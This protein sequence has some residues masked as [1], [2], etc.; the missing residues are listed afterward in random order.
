MADE[1]PPPGTPPADQQQEDD[2]GRAGGDRQVLADLAD[3]RKAR[4]AAEKAAGDAK[5]ELDQ[6]RQQSMSDADKAVAAARA[7]GRSEAL[8][9]ANE[10]LLRAEV[11]ALAANVLADPDDAV[12]L[13]DLAAY[14]ANSDGDFDRKRIK[15]D[16]DALVKSK[17]YL[18]PRPGNGA[19]EGGPRGGTGAKE[20]SMDDW[21]RSAAR[22]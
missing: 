22:R 7:E 10:R 14:E 9:T 2:K 16:L 11:R 12:H 20:P 21:L 4:Q 15:A 18:S 13:L 17:P 3:E 1:Q 6:L 19:G 5:R 8:K